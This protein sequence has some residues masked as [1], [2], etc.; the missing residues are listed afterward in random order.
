MSVLWFI[1]IVIELFKGID[2]SD[3]N[4]M[5]IGLFYIG[6]CILLTNRR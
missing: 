1:F 2:I 4:F 5:M 6:D 3:M